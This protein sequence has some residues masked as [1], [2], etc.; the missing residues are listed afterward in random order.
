MPTMSFDKRTGI[1]TGRGYTGDGVA[2]TNL[3]GRVLSDLITEA[4]TPLT[5]LPMTSHKSP[6]WEPEP[7]RWAGV[8]FVRHSRVRLLERV[9]REG[10]YPEKKTLGQRL[11]DY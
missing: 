4:D 1:A 7:F 8:T 11:Y 10:G 5:T 6:E 9:E 3:S 2:T